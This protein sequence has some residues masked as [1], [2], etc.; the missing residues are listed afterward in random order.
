MI[1]YTHLTHSHLLSKEPPPMCT[2]CSTLLTVEHI[3][4]NFSHYQ[5]IRQKYYLYSDLSNIFK[6]IPQNP[7]F[8][9]LN[10]LTC[11][12]NFELYYS[13]FVL[14]LPESLNQPTNIYCVNTYL[15]LIIIRRYYD[16]ASLFMISQIMKVLDFH[17]IWHI[18]AKCNCY[19][20]S[21]VTIQY[22]T[23]RVF[24]APYTRN[25]TGRHY[26]SHRMCV[27]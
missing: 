13:L 10:K 21:S 6:V 2:Y 22:N 16:H 23:M 4:T 3:L 26:N 14:K 20:L 27:E 5:S 17:K 7:W 18:C 25:R 11:I 12:I 19:L 9:S 15:L 24:S 8:H 1:G